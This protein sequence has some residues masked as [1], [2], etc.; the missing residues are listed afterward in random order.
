MM[1][2]LVEPCLRCFDHLGVHMRSS[3][4]HSCRSFPPLFPVAIFVAFERWQYPWPVRDRRRLH[5]QNL[6]T[7]SIVSTTTAATDGTTAHHPFNLLSL[8]F[9]LAFPL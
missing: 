4:Q 2:E 1:C 6:V 9:L 5:T 8:R 7:S 3:P